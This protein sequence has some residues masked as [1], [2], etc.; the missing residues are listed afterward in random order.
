MSRYDPTDI[1]GQA[2]TK[3]DAETRARRAK[4]QSDADFK[5]LMSEEW[6]RRIVWRDLEDAGVFRL[7]FNTNSMTMAFNEGSR[8]LGLRKLAQVHELCPD[9]YHLMLKEHTDE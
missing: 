5:R 7:S 1:A 3:A 2:R 8:N 9:L 4:E 6:G